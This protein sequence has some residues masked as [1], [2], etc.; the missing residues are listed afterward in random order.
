MVA[1]VFRTAIGQ[2]AGPVVSAVWDQVGDQPVASCPKI[3]PSMDDA[4]AEHLAFTR[5][6]RSH[7]AKIR[8]INPTE[9]INREIKRRKVPNA[10]TA[11][12]PAWPNSGEAETGTV[13]A[14]ETG[15]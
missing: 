6:P 10:A 15:N 14:I 5:F 7:R 11:P 4:K 8:P 13:A 9:R 1:P 12:K 3:G 2:P